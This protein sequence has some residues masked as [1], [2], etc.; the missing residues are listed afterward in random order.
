[1]T[2]IGENGAR[3]LGP[4]SKENVLVL[5]ISEQADGEA[6]RRHGSNASRRVNVANGQLTLRSSPHNGIDFA[7]HDPPGVHFERDF[8]LLARLDLADFVLAVN[9]KNPL[10]ILDE[11]HRGRHREGNRHCTR[12]ERQSDYGAV[13]WR[14]A[15]CLAEFPPGVV[16]LCLRA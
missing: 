12:P 2:A 7:L 15:S 13:G 6:V 9:R 8:R 16:K 1:M 10:S 4:G 5:S 14:I 11:V 3:T